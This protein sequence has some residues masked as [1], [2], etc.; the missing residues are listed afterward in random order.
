MLLVTGYLFLVMKIKNNEEYLTIG[1]K[2]PVTGNQQPAIL[3][4]A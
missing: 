3:F 4:P 1:N 2:K